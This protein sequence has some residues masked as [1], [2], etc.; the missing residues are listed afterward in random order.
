M[1]K[2]YPPVS[3]VITNYNRRDDLRE[4][5]MSLRM[6]DYPH[7]EIIVVDNASQDDSRHM[8]A[9]DFPEVSVIALGE[10]IGMDGYSVGI[11]QARG[12]FIFQMDNDSLLPDAHVVSEVI[13]RFEEGPPDLAVVAT[14]GEDPRG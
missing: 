9:R 13:K 8:L 14:R 11:R 3:V 7:L 12:K 1:P 10:N 5:L 2:Q 4:A 6:Q